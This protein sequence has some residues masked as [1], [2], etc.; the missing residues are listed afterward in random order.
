MKK[1]SVKQ[2]RLHKMIPQINFKYSFDGIAHIDRW[3]LYNENEK[4]FK[5]TNKTCIDKENKKPG[6][7]P[8][9]SEEF[10]DNLVDCK[11]SHKQEEVI[12]RIVKHE[13][14]T[15][16]L[17]N[18]RVKVLYVW[19][20]L[21]DK[22]YEYLLNGYDKLSVHYKYVKSNNNTIVFEWLTEI[23]LTNKPRDN[24]CRI[25]NF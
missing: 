8:F 23:S 12:G 19:G 13:I 14:R 6:F 20:L 5:V 2:K 4:S 10:I 1:N 9:F 3:G 16:L 21:S 22:G 17:N 25:I 11:L 24:S 7:N 15:V 18:Q